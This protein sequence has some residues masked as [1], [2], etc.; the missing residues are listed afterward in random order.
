MPYFFTLLRT[1]R[2]HFTWFFVGL[3]L[4]H[5]INPFK[6]PVILNV[7]LR[8]T[9]N[10]KVEGIPVEM[11]VDTGSVFTL[12][13][14][15]LWDKICKELPTRGKIRCAAGGSTTGLG[16]LELVK[17]QQKVV[18]ANGDPLEIMKRVNLTLSIG[19][20]EAKQS[21]WVATD[22][23]QDCILGVDFMRPHRMIVD[24]DEMILKTKKTK[25]ELKLGTENI[26]C[27]IAF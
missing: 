18:S 6:F 21:V 22:L 24:F 1:G 25:L 15:D 14:K 26:S 2:W 16:H 19:Q 7:A 5:S 12:I 23:A 17:E 20:E 10:G 11:L 9:C 13:S 3:I 8:L 27:R 4:Y